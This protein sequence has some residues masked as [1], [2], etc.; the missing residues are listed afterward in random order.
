MQESLKLQEA[1]WGLTFSKNDELETPD[2]LS[3]SF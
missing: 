1:T 3:F 2:V